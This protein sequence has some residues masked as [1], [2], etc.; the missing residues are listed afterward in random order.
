MKLISLYYYPS[1]L[2]E[3]KP[4]VR[5]LIDIDGL[6]TLE[7]KDCLAP[8]TKAAIDA[9]ISARFRTLACSIGH[10]TTQQE[11]EMA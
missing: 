10:I 8:E 11:K 5:A 1:T 4:D 6:G 9:D 3:Q 2:P 7:I